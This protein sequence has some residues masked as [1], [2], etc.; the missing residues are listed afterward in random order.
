[1]RV[2]REKINGEKFFLKFKKGTLGISTA[3]FVD[4]IF[5]GCDLLSKK[6]KIGDISVIIHT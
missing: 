2:S 4:F 5:C 1:M 6:I 3:G